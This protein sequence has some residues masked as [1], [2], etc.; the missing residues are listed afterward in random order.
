MISYMI[1]NLLHKSLDC[2]GSIVRR[3]QDP[4]NVEEGKVIFLM[5]QSASW[6]EKWG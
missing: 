6:R 5:M 2:L 3:S 1:E 4:K